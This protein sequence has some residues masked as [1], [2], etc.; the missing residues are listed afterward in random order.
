MQ[1]SFPP[2]AP[3]RQPTSVKNPLNLSSPSSNLC[4][5]QTAAA[6]MRTEQSTATPGYVV[7]EPTDGDPDEEDEEEGIIDE[8]AI[9]K[10]MC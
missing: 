5:P 2:S 8:I 4:A 3:I 1:G 9:E 6:A 10:E 7:P